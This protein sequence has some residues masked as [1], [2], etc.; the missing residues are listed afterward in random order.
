[1]R[2]LQQTEI[3]SAMYRLLHEQ[4]RTKAY[5]HVCYSRSYPDWMDTRERIRTVPESGEK[6]M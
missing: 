3:V 5:E 2:N 1:M 4:W 6:N